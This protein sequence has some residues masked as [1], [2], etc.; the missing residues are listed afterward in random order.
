[1]PAAAQL[2]LEVTAARDSLAARREERVNDE[3][4]SAALTRRPNGMAGEIGR[5]RNREG[6]LES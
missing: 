2:R 3:R 6:G 1:M 5:A 4:R